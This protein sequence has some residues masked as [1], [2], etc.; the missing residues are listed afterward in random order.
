MCFDASKKPVIKS[1]V[2]VFET[3]KA[4]GDYG[5]ATILKDG[6]GIS[7]GRSQATDGSDSLD[8]ICYAYIDRGGDL[9]D[10]LATFMPYLEKDATTKL[11]PSNPPS[12]CLELLDLLREAGADPV[13]QA[14]QDAVFDTNYWSPAVAQAEQMGLT[15]LLSY[16]V[17]YDTCIH[18]G[19][20][21][22]SKIRS[23]FPELPPARGGQEKSWA[24]AY[25]KA[26]RNWLAGHS[27]PIVQKTVYRMD[28]FQALIDQD[29][30]NLTTPFYVRK[31]K[32]G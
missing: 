5:L 1:I 2:N 19:P 8:Q 31:V 13:M 16:A 29:N 28:A 4:V 26:R 14:A 22:V 6:A 9:A 24:Q 25:V 11:D 20:G 10:R 32:I 18:S 27:N 7:Y 3:G 12:W 15:L 21:G 23:K 30:W 17:V